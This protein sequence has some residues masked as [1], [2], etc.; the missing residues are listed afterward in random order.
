MLC[1][2]WAISSWQ[3]SRTRS[4][5]TGLPKPSWLISLFWQKTH[6]SG[7]PE[8]KMVPDPRVPEMGGSSQ[9]WSAPRASTGREGIRQ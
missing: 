3:I 1:A 4:G 8:K 9:W 7:Q 5:V 2:P 6:R